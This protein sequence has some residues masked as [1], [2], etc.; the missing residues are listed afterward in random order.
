MGVLVVRHHLEAHKV[1]NTGCLAPAVLANAAVTDFGSR[2]HRFDESA[3]ADSGS[4]VLFPGGIPIADVADEIEQLVVLDGSWSQARRMRARI[5][6]IAALRSV[7]LGGALPPALTL[8]RPRRSGEL[9]TA[10]AIADALEATGDLEAAAGIRD[11]HRR[12]VARLVRPGRRR[13]GRAQRI[14]LRGR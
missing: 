3:L 1:S 8:R 4:F 11:A 2:R 13:P 12:L 9:A 7:S 14:D 5:P 10:V 6:E